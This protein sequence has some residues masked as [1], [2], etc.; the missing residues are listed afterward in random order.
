VEHVDKAF[1]AT[2][3][4]ADISF[5][6]GSGEVHA[7]LG[8]NG[9][10]KSTLLSIIAGLFLPDRGVLRLGGEP[11]APR[12]A[13]A[14]REAGIAIVPQEPMLATDLTVRE[15]V[16][17]GREPT[18]FGLVDRDEARRITS[19]AL[20][21]LGVTIDPDNAVASL[22][23]AER[24][25]VTIARALS[26]GSARLLIL[27][28][29]TSSLSAADAERVLEA[30]RKLASSG[31]TIIYVSHHLA[32]VKSIAT[33]FTVMRAGRV[34]ASGNVASVSVGEMAD[35]IL[36]RSLEAAAKALRSPGEVLLSL[37]S[38]AGKR[39]PHAA[40]LTLRRGEILGVAGLVGAGRTELCRAIF[41]LD[42]IR[43][44]AVKIGTNDADSGRPP[45]QRLKSGVGL[46]SEDRKGEGLLTAM[47]V[48]DNMTLSNLGGVSQW[49][50]V[51]KLAQDK[52][53]LR[54]FAELGIRA[55]GPRALAS[56][57]SGGNQQKVA[58]AR[59]LFQDVDVFL[60]DEPTR[61]VDPG[62]RES[63]Y[64][65]FEAL[66]ERGKAIL[67]VSSQPAELIRVCDRVA[68]MV[69]GR[70][71]EMRDVSELDESRLLAA[72]SGS[73]TPC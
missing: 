73:A 14:A 48:A 69:R 15:N 34:V 61:G 8:E 57:L 24:Q 64:R 33:R 2:V 22:S 58:I 28:E 71:G 66:A 16:T 12:S 38:V 39:L 32:E 3:A 70:L 23:P 25:I 1:G 51:S 6:I 17:L 18:R 55:S 59:L 60:L 68:V 44:G 40:S 52:V 26:Q 43:S 67:W 36:G 49:G 53:A 30:V 56:S 65:L 41:G 42:T 31:K 50:L 35:L 47:S 9:A 11:F 13:R 72:A 5:S 7:L 4:L 45:W 20:T 63:I 62:S 10:G 27:D 46:L 21:T 29:P 54:L 19:T 37:D